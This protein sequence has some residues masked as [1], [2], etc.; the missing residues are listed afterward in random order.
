MSRDRRALT[1]HRILDRLGPEADAGQISVLLIGMVS[2][3]LVLILGVVGTTS[4]Q[5]SRIHLLD[6]ADAAALAAADS[7]DEETIY[8]AGLGEGLPLTSEGVAA[9][10]QDYLARQPRPD[11]LASWQVLPG[12]GTPDARTAVVRLQGEARIPVVS[13]VL[14]SLGGSVSITV[15]SRARSEL[16]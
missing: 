10:A 13:R 8:G 4:V 15:E 1:Q 16:D 2:I 12:T 6:A 5:L 7:V 11:R 3:A 14:R 9:A